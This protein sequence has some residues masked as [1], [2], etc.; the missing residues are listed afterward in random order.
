MTGEVSDLLV[1]ETCG[2]GSGRARKERD[3]S[4]N[5]VAL[6]FKRFQ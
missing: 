1:Q 4:E 3:G 2:Q 6:N 5:W